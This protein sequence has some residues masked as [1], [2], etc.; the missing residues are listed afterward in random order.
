LNAPYE[1]TASDAANHVA[2]AG[3]EAIFRTTVD[4]AVVVKRWDKPHGQSE[5]Q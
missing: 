3:H 4:A 2:E 1:K 5:Q